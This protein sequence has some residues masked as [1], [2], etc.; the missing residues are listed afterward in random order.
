MLDVRSAGAGFISAGNSAATT[1][2]WIYNGGANDQSAIG[3]PVGQDMRLGTATSIIGAGFVERMRITSGGNIGVGT[4]APLARLHV[5]NGGTPVTSV[6]SDVTRDVVIEGPDAPFN[7][8]TA[9]LLI[10]SNDTVA[11]D[12]GGSLAF[13]SKYNGNNWSYDAGIKGGKTDGNTGAYGGYLSFATR[14]NGGGA[15]ERMRITGDGNV[16]INAA[17]SGYSLNV[18]GTFHAT[19]AITSDG[20][21]SAVFQDVAE[22]V[23]SSESLTP[24]TV[25]VVDR[26]RQNHVTTSST[27]Y[28]TTVA[29]VV[30]ERPGIALGKAAPDRAQIATTGRVKV[31]ADASTAPI[32]MGDLLVTSGVKGTAMKSVPME[33]DGRRFHQPGTIVGKALEPLDSGTGEILVLL[34][35]Q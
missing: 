27:A 23:P 19:G 24:G 16:T 22:W 26:V 34:S 21:I 28:D 20:S 1:Y 33:I 32:H 7:T 4:S 31:K 30:S 18:S 9:Q 6:Y 2:T 13:G 11:A 14:P 3:W 29:G 12:R 35:L 17:A 5:L 8:Q 15:T 25:V 10:I